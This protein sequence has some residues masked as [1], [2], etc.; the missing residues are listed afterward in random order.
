MSREHR[1]RILLSVECSAGKA[2]CHRSELCELSTPRRLSEPEEAAVKRGIYVYARRMGQMREAQ[3]RT[4]RLG[5]DPAGKPDMGV[6]AVKMP[7]LISSPL[8]SAKAGET[9]HAGEILQNIR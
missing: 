2:N 6:K 3:R 1:K 4:A 9:S 7:T 8:N 5:G